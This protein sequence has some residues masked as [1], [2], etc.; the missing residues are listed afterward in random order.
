M[1][2]RFLWILLSCIMALT[3]VAW[4]CNGGAGEQEEEE[5]EEEEEGPPVTGANWWDKFGEPQYGGIL[6]FRTAALGGTNVNVYR[7]TGAP[8]HHWLERLFNFDWTID[9]EEYSFKGQFVAVEHHVGVLAES[10]EQ[11][12]PLTFIVHIRKGVYWQDKPPVYGRAFTAHDV[13]YQYDQLLGTG[14]GATEPNPFLIDTIPNIERVVA[15]DDYT[16]EFRFKQA[17]A[18]N[19]YDIIMPS[20]TT[21]IITPREWAEQGDL[22]NWRNAVGTGP[23]ILT[24]V[25]EGTYFNYSRNPNYWG[26]DERHPENQLPYLDEFRVVQIA[27]MSAALAALR[28]PVRLI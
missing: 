23:W 28:T 20:R 15:T 9:R 8:Y 2:R 11:V 4:S 17:N 26:Y 5:E 1:K 21:G 7:P 25:M 16:V 24:D 3:L 6:K 14:S 18:F 27:D 19:I 13:Q 22:N 10:W 12:D